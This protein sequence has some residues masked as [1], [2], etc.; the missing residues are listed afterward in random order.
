MDDFRRDPPLN[1]PLVLR[2]DVQVI[3]RFERVGPS[4]TQLTV[5][6]TINL[7]LTKTR[8]ETQRTFTALTLEEAPAVELHSKPPAPSIDDNMTF[9]GGIHTP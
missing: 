1:R 3:E 7:L 8:S 6:M 9:G 5:Y 4:F 2:V